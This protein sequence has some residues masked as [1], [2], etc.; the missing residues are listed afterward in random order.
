VQEAR[1]APG[2]ARHIPT[3]SLRKVNSKDRR[4]EITCGNS[5]STLWHV[6]AWSDSNTKIAGITNYD[7]CSTSCET[8]KFGAQSGAQ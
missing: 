1:L 6:T 5:Y 2:T 3:N 4:T 8:Q 7:L